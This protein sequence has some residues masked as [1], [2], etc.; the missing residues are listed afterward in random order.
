MGQEKKKLNSI[1]GLLEKQ[2]HL[3]L[4]WGVRT[5]GSVVVDGRDGWQ[6]NVAGF[7]HQGAVIIF[8]GEVSKHYDV[9]L[10]D[11][12][13]K[14]TQM[15]ECVPRKS[16]VKVIDQAVEVTE[17]YVGDIDNWIIAPGTNYNPLQKLARMMR[18]KKI[19]PRSKVIRRNV[20]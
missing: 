7:K 9:K 10:Y 16:L 6:L 8:P 14:E 12:N 1:R 18:R 2:V 5:G 13:G 11:R 15:F 19:V 17:N 20:P 4:A 3:M